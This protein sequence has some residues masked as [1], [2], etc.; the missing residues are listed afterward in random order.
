MKFL[1][2][3]SFGT[4]GL[5]TVILTVATLLEKKYD[6]PFVIEHIYG[7]TWFVA[8]WGISATAAIF[9][10]LKQKIHLRPATFLLHSAFAIILLG[11]FITWNQ[12]K[13]GSLHLRLDGCSVNSFSDRKGNSISFPFQ[14]ELEQFEIVR[15][16]GTQAPMDYISTLSLT[17]GNRTIRGEVAMN[18]I[19]RHKG[20]RF[21]QS[22]YDADR[23]GTT[24]SVTYDPIGIGITY[25]GYAL[26]L[27]SMIF[28][29]FDKKSGF[30]QLLSHPSLKRIA[31]GLFI[32]GCIPTASAATT[33]TSVPREVADELGNLYVYYND[34]IC[35]LSTLARD[36]TTKLC[37]KD[38]YRN[39]SAEQVLA[40]WMFHYDEWKYEPIIKIKDPQVR[41]LLELEGKQ[42]KLTDFIGTSGG[43]RLQE[44][45]GRGFREADERFNLIS[46]IATG[47][48]LCI[49]PYTDPIDG[50]LHWASPID[51][52][53]T[54]IA[55]EERL[56]IR[57]SMN[58]V[59]ELIVKQEYANACIALQ[60][61]RKW[62][63]KQAGDTLPTEWEIEAERIYNRTN[64]PI[65]A[66][67]FFIL[68]GIVTFI[69]VCLQMARQ[70]PIRRRSV[71]LP[72]LIVLSG[73]L[74]LSG[75]ITL[76]GYICGHL[77]MTNGYETMQLMAWCALLMSL[78]FHRRFILLL[79]LGLLIAGL[80]MMVSMIGASNP[81][82]TPLMPVL[83]SPLLSIHV[84]SVMI[85]YT[86]FAFI[87]LNGIAGLFINLHRP[88]ES[89]RLVVI[90]RLLLY[91]AVFVLT[92]GIFIGAV[93]ANISWG[94]YCGWD[95]K[96]VWALITLLVYSLALHT[97]SFPRFRQPV[98]FHTFSIVAFLCVLI[99]YFGV[100][101]LLG[102]M[103][104]YA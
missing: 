42:A 19:F 28:F 68:S 75:M 80:A 45:S 65:F 96:E 53:P 102:G 64:R 14:I 48:L 72:V 15:Y 63:Q 52:L 43:Y 2:Y 8:L 21:Y 97:A 1:K 25:T 7:A 20:Y 103:H 79:P 44:F 34:R 22:A 23:S 46:M 39:L 67:V 58:Y 31:L 66:S 51:D 26:L 56:F 10:L 94:R 84:M 29:P 85:S 40:G 69:F 74:Y 18:R 11:S 90:S 101:F 12:G 38:S 47:R 13:Q 73:I 88:E 3:T 5:L 6:T 91:P 60:K 77:P 92:I 37:G 9:Y 100:N 4:L 41:R 104:S 76:R 89:T 36:F 50:S 55:H 61:I 59:T 98:F 95:P 30:R 87:A 27:L 54:D 32:S 24:L 17:D 70:C 93:W 83:S 78:L 33:V 62:Q 16:P 35:P 99:T 82:I 49:Y 71:L 57:Q 81:Q 86:L